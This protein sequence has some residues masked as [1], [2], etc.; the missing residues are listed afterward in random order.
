M[1]VIESFP[2]PVC[3]YVFGWLWQVCDEDRP[4]SYY[5]YKCGHKLD[6]DLVVE[7]GGDSDPNDMEEE[8]E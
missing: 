7:V 8:E 5:C 1:P 3:G 2:C 6:D 4:D